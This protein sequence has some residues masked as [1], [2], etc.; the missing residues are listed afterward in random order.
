MVAASLILMSFRAAKIL[1]KSSAKP[2]VKP[3]QLSFST[4][5]PTSLISSRVVF[6]ATLAAQLRARW[7]L[8]FDEGETS[9]EVEMAPNVDCEQLYHDAS[10]WGG[11]N[12]RWEEDSYE[13]PD[14][15]TSGA[16][17][18]WGILKTVRGTPPSASARK[19]ASPNCLPMINRRGSQSIFVELIT[20]LF[21]VWYLLEKVVKY[22]CPSKVVLHP[23]CDRDC[24]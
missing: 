12:K 10:V 4:I 5:I 11:L 13:Y 2:T 16:K 23:D 14:V 6:W 22:P 20:S 15:K 8:S 17:I 7:K 3:V 19:A 24:L 9:V 1:F 21:R 18:A